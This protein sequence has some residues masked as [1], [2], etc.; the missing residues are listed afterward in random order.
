MQITLTLEGEP[1]EVRR[2][3]RVLAY[4][5]DS[6]NEWNHQ[7]NVTSTWVETGDDDPRT[8]ALRV[9]M[10]N[11]AIRAWL[12]ANDPQALKQVAAALAPATVAATK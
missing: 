8:D 5:L 2:V 3:S 11:P 12:E 7:P 1:A 10:H 4:T 9:I 6:P